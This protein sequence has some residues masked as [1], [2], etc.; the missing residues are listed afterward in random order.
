M[1]NRKKLPIGVTEFSSI[2]KENYYYIDKTK[3]IEDLFADGAGVTLFTRPRRFGKTLNMSMLKYFFDIE[4]KDKNKDLFKGLYIEKSPSFKEQGQYP[5]IYISLKDLK[6]KT[7]EEMSSNILGLLS[8]VFKNSLFLLKELNEFDLEI[9]RN[10]AGK[11]VEITEVKTSLKFLTELLYKYYSK[12]VIILI[13]EYDTALISAY[14]YKY[15]DEAI[16][17]FRTFFSSALKDNEYLQMGVMTG[18]L[19]VAKEGIFSGLNNLLVRTVLNEHYSTYFGLVE[20]EV[21]E[22]LKFYDMDYKI[23]EVKEWYN[24]YKFGGTEIYNPWSIINYILNKKLEAY[25]IGTSDNM[26]IHNLLEKADENIFNDFRKLFEGKEIEKT[27]DPSFS[28]KNLR[29]SQEVWQLLIHSGYLKTE[30]E[31]ENNRYILKIPNKEIYSFFEKDFINNFLGGV[32]LFREMLDALK[33]ENIRLFENKL[34]SILATNISYYDGAKEE[35]YYHNLVLG[36]IL[37]MMNEYIISSN[38]ES[39]YGRYDIAIEPKN[40]NKTA[41]LLEFKVADTEDKLEL[42][43]EEALKQIEENEYELTLKNRGI[44]K[45]IKLGIAFYKKKVKILLK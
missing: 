7:W 21:Q 13:D 2:I 22:I 19:R 12:K 4:N 34:Q 31:L 40:K 44:T 11:K 38:V 9:F 29:N 8:D 35:K 43:C 24:G 10:I 16:S 5:V 14:E 41:F 33:N 25:W 45:I 3:M 30:K 26:L 37:S 15:Y 1:N 27:L 36:M 20:E 42:M 28:F 6:E 32:D 18:I 39:G 23:N 17:F